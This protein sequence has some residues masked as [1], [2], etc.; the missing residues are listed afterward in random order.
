MWQGLAGWF[1][2]LPARVVAGLFLLPFLFGFVKAFFKSV[3]WFTDF[4]AIACAGNA[5]NQGH[6]IYTSVRDCPLFHPQPYVYTPIGAHFFALIQRT[7]GITTEVFLFGAIYCVLLA[8]VL[9]H[10]WRDDGQLRLRAPFLTGISASA[11]H[12]GN[13]SIIIHAGIF[14]VATALPSAPWALVPLVMLAGALK[15]TFAVYACL[16]LFTCRP[17][18]ERLLLS[19]ISLVMIVGYLAGFAHLSAGEFAE[20]TQAVASL[21]LNFERGHSLFGLPFIAQISSPPALGG[22]YLIFAAALG[23]AALAVSHLWLSDPIDRVSFGV[24]VCILLYPRLMDYDQYTLPFGLAALLQ[25]WLLVRGE[26]ARMPLRLVQLGCLLAMILGGRLGGEW[27]FVMSSLLILSLGISA[28][29]TREAC[30]LPL[31][32]ARC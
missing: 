10:L 20:W 1:D 32:R 3:P 16:F 14:L 23:S 15:P 9:H 30:G 22:I 5:L 28:W 27:L 6:S 25:G 7:L 31:S 4:E 13:V 17:W 21:G 8:I 29:R 12:S 19:G 11:L 26:S 24:S 18:W 2:R